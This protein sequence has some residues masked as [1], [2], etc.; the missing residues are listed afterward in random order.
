MAAGKAG[1]RNALI[2]LLILAVAAALIAVLLATRDGD[3]SAEPAPTGVTNAPN[4]VVDSA[5][6]PTAP[7]RVN[8]ER[9]EADDPLAIGDADAPV[10][11]VMYSDFQCP[12]CALWTTETLPQLM[13][14]VD[15]G[16]LRIEW[17]DI[18]IF[19]PESERAAIA[20]YA[21]GEQGEY[22][23]FHEAL[24][25]GG[26]APDASQLSEEGLADLAESLGLD[27]EA[28]RAD[29]ADSQVSA[30]VQRNIDEAAE[31]GAFSTP[32]FLVNGRP[33]VGAQ[34]A[35]VFIEAIDAE[36]AG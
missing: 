16:D 14:Y 27:M 15:A 22:L 4:G 13:G 17:R 10:A 11:L 19:G 29:I 6:Q 9:R 33:V 28:Y 18:A 5:E 36:L 3:T 20:A 12:F 34:P 30:A 26:D 8:T 23:P 35:N 1:R 21:A 32:A 24:F 31:L 7:T 25:E 2:P